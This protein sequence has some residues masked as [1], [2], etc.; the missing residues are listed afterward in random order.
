MAEEVGL[1]HILR[2]ELLATWFISVLFLAYSEKK[3]GKSVIVKIG[4]A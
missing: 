4:H 3:N 1:S 2:R